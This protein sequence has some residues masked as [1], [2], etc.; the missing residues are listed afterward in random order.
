MW[1]RNVPNSYQVLT[2]LEVA[3]MKHRT[4][5]VKKNYTPNFAEN[6]LV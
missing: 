4:G 6:S 2:N 3:I 5:Y 1:F